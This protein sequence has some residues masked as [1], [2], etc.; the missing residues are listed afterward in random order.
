MWEI[1]ANVRGGL[2]ALAVLGAMLWPAAASA[3]PVADS[4]AEYQA[5]GRVFPDPLAGCQN[6]GA[7]PCSPNAQGN[8]PATQF[9]QFGEFVDA[10]SYMNQQAEWKRYMEV[11]PLATG[12]FPGNDLRRL[13]FQPRAEYVSAGLPTST[14]ERQKSN[15]YVVRVTDETVPDRDK[16]R[17]TLSLS[18]HGIERA[19]AEGGTR[20]M[21]DLVT[22]ATTGRGGDGILPAGVEGGGPTFDE[23]LRNTIIY[24]TY[25]NPDGWRRG[26]VTEGGVFYQR[27]NGNGVDPNR[28]WPDIGFSF[29]P[30]SG[31]SE[32]ETRAFAGFYNDVRGRGGDFAAGDDLHGQP[33]ADAL[34]YTLL[35]HGKHSYAKDLRIR[36]AAITIHN[37]SEEALAWSPMVQPSD[38]PRGGGLPCI[39]TLGATCAQIYGQTWGTVYDTINYTTTG[40]LGDWFDSTKGLNADG[41]DNEMSFSHLDKN[42]VF[43]PHTEQLHVDGNKA[44]IY[45]HVASLLDP[46]SGQFVATGAK[47]YVPNTRLTREAQLTQRPRGRRPQ[48]PIEMGPKPQEGSQTIYDAADGL[49]VLPGNGGMRVEVTSANAQGIAPTYVPNANQ[50]T[51]QV[52]CQ[53]EDHHGPQDTREPEWTVVA[54]DYNQRQLYLSAG[55]VATVN[56]PQGR[57]GDGDPVPWR[58]VIGG[59]HGATSAKVTFTSGPASSD[60]NTGGDEPPSLDAYDV[61]NTDFFGDLNQFTPAGQG[62]QAVQ[63][64]EVI[65]G[66]SSLAGLDSLVLAD[67][68]LPGYS[69]GFGLPAGG[70]SPSFTFA[71][72]QP[73]IPGARQPDFD[74]AG[75][76]ARVPGSYE[77]KE[78]DVAADAVNKSMTVTVTWPSD[79]NDF[80]T[81]LYRVEEG[82]ERLIGSSTSGSTNSERIVVGAPEP[83]HYKLYVDNWLSDDPQWQGSVDFEAYPAAP[84]ET[85]AYTPEEA[86]AWVAALRDFVSGGGNLV[87]TDRALTLL[88]ELTTIPAGS[89]AEKTVYVGQVA[90]SKGEGDTLDDPLADDVDQPGARFNEGM[91]RQTYEPTP[92][93]FAIQN[94][95]GGDESH[96][97]QY[98]VNREAFEAAGGR[99][100][101]GSANS[102]ARD[103]EAVYDRVTVGELPLGAGR[104]RIVG[105]LLPQPTAAYDHPLGI[106]PYAVTYT[107]YILFRNLIDWT[108]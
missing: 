72:Q 65:A 2:L 13:E 61:A 78:W 107:G 15:L 29:R 71:S 62:F 23:V 39:E 3:T 81:Y 53:C 32:P 52:Q 5:L 54:E 19:G 57:T 34:S 28:D 42:I 100:V 103:A 77:T 11:W 50:V 37:A 27:Y 93:G 36:D 46:P 66:T 85:G 90:F 4:D 14:L 26:S 70:P 49:H 10:L 63:P 104:I 102:G 79:A 47:G 92:L 94:A 82:E 75:S 58:L 7:S 80:D 96:A 98:D 12:E 106:E 1:R 35:P 67:D 105:A 86:A 51:L 25:P 56:R 74:L 33:F 6:I 48:G 99:M 30:Y 55:L 20:A 68:P 97:V 8:V 45:A 24:F 64:R 59:Q 17:Y 101:A 84:S 41:I 108:R 21:E 73:T 83:G 69:G 9:I 87:L 38:E 40:T 76:A 22:A 43:D 88:P 31:L 89:V 16:K 44:L 60:G 18:I 95:S 91:R